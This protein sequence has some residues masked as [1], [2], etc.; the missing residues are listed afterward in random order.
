M[1]LRFLLFFLLLPD[2][3]SKEAAATATTAAT[4]ALGATAGC[5]APKKRWTDVWYLEKPQTPGMKQLIQ[6]GPIRLY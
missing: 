3:S 1:N 2:M 5:Y 6:E 4:A